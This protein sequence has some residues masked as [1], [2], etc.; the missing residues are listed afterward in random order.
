MGPGDHSD[1]V[2]SA[3]MDEH[4]DRL[5]DVWR[6][7][8]TSVPGFLATFGYMALNAD[9][10]CEGPQPEFGIW[11]QGHE[12]I[13]DHTYYMLRCRLT[14]PTRKP[15]RDWRVRRR[16]LHLRCGLHD[17]V[18]EAL[19]VATYTKLFQ[20]APFARRLGPPG[21]SDRLKAW[22][23]VLAQCINQ[24]I[25]TPLTTA[26]ALR[27]LG[28]Q[29]SQRTSAQAK[30]SQQQTTADA[31]TDALPSFP[32]SLRETARGALAPAGPSCGTEEVGVIADV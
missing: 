24:R 12:D 26:C 16:L 8:P 13:A 17:P 28:L 29:G 9:H 18:K 3:A 4:V 11:V 22:C 5:I 30:P 14:Q 1:A 21:T 6:N 20:D 23:F 25:L 10:W 15:A 27:V 31:G 2:S 7:P 19:G 32:D